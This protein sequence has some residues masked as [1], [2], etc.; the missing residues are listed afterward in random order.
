LQ[1]QAS[2]VA[3]SVNLSVGHE[4][5]PLTRPEIMRFVWSLT[6]SIASQ[7]FPDGIPREECARRSTLLRTA[8]QGYNSGR[9]AGRAIRNCNRNGRA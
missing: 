2:G 7:L 3:D 6:E 5:F 8:G 4:T 1:V 9:G